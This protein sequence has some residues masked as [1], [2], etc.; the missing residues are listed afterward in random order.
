MIALK[1]LL[2]ILATQKLVP[3]KAMR[4]VIIFK[5]SIKNWV[6]TIILQKFRND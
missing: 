2:Q 5:D 3:V 4:S 1:Y 6:E